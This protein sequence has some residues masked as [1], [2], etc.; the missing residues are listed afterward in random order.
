MPSSTHQHR[1]EPVRSLTWPLPIRIAATGAPSLDRDNR[2]FVQATPCKD[3]VSLFNDDL[4]DHPDDHFLSPIRADE[5]KDW[6]SES[7]SD[8]E[9]VE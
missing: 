1:R 6:D 5:Y 8:A 4:E 9:E 7:D 2:R 3:R